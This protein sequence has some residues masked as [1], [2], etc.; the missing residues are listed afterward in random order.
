[1]SKGKVIL[2][3]LLVML[4]LPIGG[5]IGFIENSAIVAPVLF[6]YKL[7]EAALGVWLLAMLLLG[8]ILGWSVSVLSHFRLRSKLKR[9]TNKLKNQEKE[10]G[11]LRTRGL[12]D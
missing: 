1:M 6:G 2:S 11:N 9:A 4:V 10:L 5:W 8:S 7:P 12:R 3:W